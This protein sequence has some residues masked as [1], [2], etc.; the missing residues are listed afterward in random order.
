MNTVATLSTS[1][2][3]MTSYSS[4]GPTLLD[5]LVKP[6]LLAP[7]NQVVSLQAPGS[8][9]VQDYPGSEVS[10]GL[11]HNGNSNDVSNVY[12]ELSGSS[13]ATPM[14]SGGCA[15]AATRPDAHSGSGEG[16]L[17]E[18]RYQAS[19]GQNYGDRPGHWCHIL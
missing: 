3:K 11:Y 8:N 5:H 6:D 16:S 15:D 1:D 14:V 17:D 9:L 2:D 4:K 10:K 7:G 12:F 18:N 19:F 13:L